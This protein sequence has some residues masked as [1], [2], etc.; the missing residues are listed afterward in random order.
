MCSDSI[1]ICAVSLCCDALSWC[2][3]IPSLL[4]VLHAGKCM[5]CRSPVIFTPANSSFLQDGQPS[6]LFYYS[7]QFVL[8]A[9]HPRGLRLHQQSPQGRSASYYTCRGNSARPH[10]GGRSGSTVSVRRCR[11]EY[12]IL[13]LC[14]A[15]QLN[16]FRGKRWEEPCLV[17]VSGDGLMHYSLL[18][19][20]Y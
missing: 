13:H 2:P 19:A 16:V 10:T 14:P 15:S 18:G 17:C 11:D 5:S 9:R 20:S 1:P 6:S 4:F 3:A 8:L 7:L 12:P